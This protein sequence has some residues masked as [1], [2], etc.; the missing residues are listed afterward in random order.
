MKRGQMFS[1]DMIIA[2]ILI[3]ASLAVLVQLKS[4]FSDRKMES[5]R[6]VKL[7]QLSSDAAAL[8]YYDKSLEEFN[9][10]V[11]D[12]GYVILDGSDTSGYNSCMKGVRGTEKDPVE[13]FVC[14]KG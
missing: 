3:V 10:S 11:E 7:H 12:Q 13:V 1:L 5:L 9:N 14:E 6:S 2:L 4:T 8:A